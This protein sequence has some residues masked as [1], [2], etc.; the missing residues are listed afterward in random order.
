M[1]VINSSAKDSMSQFE[2]FL[3]RIRALVTFDACEGIQSG[4]QG[5]LMFS[6]EF[7]KVKR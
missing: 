2:L 4:D 6:D 5:V 3:V 1:I 7:Q